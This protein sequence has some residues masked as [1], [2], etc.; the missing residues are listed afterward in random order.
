MESW[1]VNYRHIR[2]LY[3]EFDFAE[4]PSNLSTLANLKL[5]NRQLPRRPSRSFN[6]FLQLSYKIIIFGIAPVGF[7]ACGQL[8]TE[9][10][11]GLI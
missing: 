11:I 7:Q 6:Q 1:N 3:K 2:D 4:K 10:K 8:P 9:P 5:F